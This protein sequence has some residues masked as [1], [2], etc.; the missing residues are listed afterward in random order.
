MGKKADA[1]DKY[2]RKQTDGS[3][4]LSFCMF[5]IGDPL[6]SVTGTRKRAHLLRLPKQGVRICERN[7]DFDPAQLNRMLIDLGAAEQVVRPAALL[8]SSA[9]VSCPPSTCQLLHAPSNMSRCL[10]NTRFSKHTLYEMR[11]IYNTY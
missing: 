7:G 9:N 3:V 10:I 6:R 5:C 4:V 2:F 11:L 1:S 8:K